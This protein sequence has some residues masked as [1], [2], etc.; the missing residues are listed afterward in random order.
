MTF[1]RD[2]GV[3]V[4]DG[5]VITKKEVIELLK[6]VDIG[7]ENEIEGDSLTLFEDIQLPDGRTV[8]HHSHN[9]TDKIIVGEVVDQIDLMKIKKTDHLYIYSRFLDFEDENSA[10]FTVSDVKNWKGKMHEFYH[11]VY[12][13][14]DLD[15]QEQDDQYVTKKDEYSVHYVKFGGDAVEYLK[16]QISNLKD[17]YYLVPTGDCVCCS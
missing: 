5:V 6:D 2:C 4:V 1:S 10:Y 15:Y 7:G 11:D 12:D 8:F 17:Q 9:H 14:S 13:K 3:A 16:S